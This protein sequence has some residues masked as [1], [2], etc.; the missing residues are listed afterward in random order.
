MSGRSRVNYTLSVREVEQVRYMVLDR[1]REFRR[2]N[3]V[4]KGWDRKEQVNVK[5]V[6]QF[7]R[8]KVKVNAGVSRCWQK[9]R[10]MVAK[11]ESEVKK[12]HV[13]QNK[14]ILKEKNIFVEHDLTRKKRKVQEKLGR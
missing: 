11:L 5:Q 7:L 4:I 1:E 10:M 2:N 8:D 13:M 12:R 14:S 6:E 3:I 9:E